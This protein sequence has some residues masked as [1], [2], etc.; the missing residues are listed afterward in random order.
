[1][2][3]ID[4]NKLKETMI[5]NNLLVFSNSGTTYQKSGNEEYGLFVRR[6]DTA[7]L[8]VYFNGKRLSADGTNY[9]IVRLPNG[10]FKIILL[11]QMLD[12]L[13]EGS[14]TLTLE[15]QG[16]DDINIVIDVK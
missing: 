10:M 1:M 9:R 7:L 2:K 12:A 11:K 4:I 15:F 8:N 13:D 16:S 6:S 5:L 3:E 14:Y